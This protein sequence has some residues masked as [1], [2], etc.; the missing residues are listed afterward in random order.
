[1]SNQNR[2]ARLCLKGQSQRV[3]PR[4]PPSLHLALRRCGVRPS[5]FVL[6]VNVTAQTMQ[7]LERAPGPGGT[8]PQYHA[9]KRYLISTS[10]YGVGQAMNSNRTPLGLHRIAEKIGSGQPIG[11]IF[12]SRQVGGLTWQGA[13]DAKIVHRILWLDGLESGFNRGGAVDSYRRYIYIHGFGDESTLGRPTSHG[14]IHV[15]AR[16]LM[17]LFDLVPVGTL[18]WIE[19]R[20]TGSFR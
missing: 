5:R 10:A 14:C 17:P 6:T 8:F 11:T 16:D 13:P 15:A 20:S 7:L 19:E 1:V 18:V 3:V 12:R 9:R 4:L 2:G